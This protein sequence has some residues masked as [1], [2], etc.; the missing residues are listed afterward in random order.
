MAKR[1]IIVGDIH[2]RLRGNISSWLRDRFILLAKELAEK[3][4][5]I[6]VL[7]G[8]I[9][10]KA[11]I[12]FEEMSAFYTF[13]NIIHNSGKEVIV[14]SGNHEELTT[15]STTFDFIPQHNFTYYKK[16]VITIENVDL[17]FV[18]HP[19]ISD[20][21]S[22]ASVLTSKYKVLIS[23][24]R[25]KLRFAEEEVDNEAVSNLF[26]NTIL[27]D[28]HYPYN[29]LPNISY[30]SSPYST[31]FVKDVAYGYMQLDIS[32]GAY[33]IKFLPLDLPCLKLIEVSVYDCE[34]LLNKLSTKHL[35][36]IRIFGKENFNLVSMMEKNDKIVQFEFIEKEVVEQDEKI[37][38]DLIADIKP[39]LGV[40]FFTLLDALL[41]EEYRTDRHLKL[42]HTS[43]QGIL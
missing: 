38:K 31:A 34:A 42:G 12:N 6:I 26:N 43:L 35:Y 32:L 30:T 20:I 5:D 16:K 25:S 24:Y 22:E 29:P 41:P 8:D 7:N 36:K 4:A 28:I 13:I 27:S 10:D 11:Q 15:K 37:I 33:K 18:G 9:F 17:L 39:R 23:H 40:D 2:L 3:E 21:F 1:L 19:Y 14:I